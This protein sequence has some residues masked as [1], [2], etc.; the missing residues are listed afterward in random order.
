MSETV[1]VAWCKTRDCIAVLAI[2][3]IFASQKEL[4]DAGWILLDDDVFCPACALQA[5]ADKV[6]NV[7]KHLSL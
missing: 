3:G 5:L 1:K 4:R 6:N 7:L 2:E